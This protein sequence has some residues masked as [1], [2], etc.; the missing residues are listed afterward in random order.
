MLNVNRTVLS[1]LPTMPRQKWGLRFLAV[2]AVIAFIGLSASCSSDEIQGG[3]MASRD[4]S[5]SNA[6][7]SSS[8]IVWGLVLEAQ[9]ATATIR[10]ERALVGT[11]SGSDIAVGLN[12]FD[13][14]SV[15]RQAVFVLDVETRKILANPNNE[16][17]TPR[18]VIRARESLPRLEADWTNLEMVRE[19]IAG[20]DSAVEVQS[21]VDDEAL[22]ARITHVD[23][24]LGGSETPAVGDTLEVPSD[25]TWDLSRT[26]G[27]RHLLLKRAAVG[28]WTVLTEPFGPQ[29]DSEVDYSLVGSA[30]GR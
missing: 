9:S 15:G 21:E 20:A 25:A 13:A 11:I 7:K 23:K 19:G 24:V 28:E 2:L 4:D 26:R 16:F 17:L 1:R 30:A 14:P 10:V 22:T 6:V 3:T 12:G 29:Y 5:D 18:R 8:L 27:F